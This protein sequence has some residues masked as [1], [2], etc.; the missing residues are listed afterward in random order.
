MRKEEKF[1]YLMIGSNTLSE[2]DRLMLPIFE[3]QL[4]YMCQKYGT[5]GATVI[6]AVSSFDKRGV[7]A[8]VSSSSLINGKY[9]VPFVSALGGSKEYIKACADH[10]FVHIWFKSHKD[11]RREVVNAICPQLEDMVSNSK[12]LDTKL[13]DRMWYCHERLHNYM[14]TSL[15]V[16]DRLAGAEDVICELATCIDS[17][18]KKEVFDMIIS[19]NW[20]DNDLFTI[21]AS[22]STM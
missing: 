9:V 5:Y 22:I 6:P 20:N 1:L 19:G 3:K 4:N 13:F 10:E 15:E 2:K 11:T 16:S 7:V 18:V 14:D 12:D 17:P 21:F 8:F